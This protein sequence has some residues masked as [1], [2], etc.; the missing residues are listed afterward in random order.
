MKAADVFV[1]KMWVF[2]KNVEIRYS[3]YDLYTKTI[4]VYCYEHGKSLHSNVSLMV[5]KRVLQG[6]VIC[7]EKHSAVLEDLRVYSGTPGWIGRRHFFCTLTTGKVTSPN[8]TGGTR[9]D[10]LSK[11]RATEDKSDV[12]DIDGEVTEY[13]D[14]KT[15]S[16]I[17]VEDNLVHE[18]D[19]HSNSDT[20][21][22]IIHPF[23]L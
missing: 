23:N 4:D 16:E 8:P 7:P 19:N 3:V 1:I 22:C 20:N 17:D 13:R 21:A 10:L 15:D 18:E 6:G 5:G 9:I 2:D 14:H 11:E 12:S